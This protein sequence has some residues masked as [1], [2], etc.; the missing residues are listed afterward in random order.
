MDA[1]EM[2]HYFTRRWRDGEL[3][4][5]DFE[6]A[7][8]AYQQHLTRLLPALPSRLRD[9]VTSTISL[10]DAQVQRATFT[11]DKSFVLLLRAGD[12]QRGY[13]DLTLH[14][15]EVS[16]LDGQPSPS[17]VLNSEDAEVIQDEIDVVWA[18]G[19]FEHR[20]LFDPEGELSVRFRSFE[21]SV[22]SVR[23]RAF[24]REEHALVFE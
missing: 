11:R 14:Y 19:E 6:G 21:Y 15:F 24:K 16:Q 3:A 4:D 20:F 1:S 9:L 5:A 10:H 22:S 2:M 8:T 18:N 23:D 17:V 7:I 12:L 13:L